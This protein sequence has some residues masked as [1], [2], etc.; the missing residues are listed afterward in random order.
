MYSDYVISTMKK[1][2]NIESIIN[3]NI[4]V[5]FKPCN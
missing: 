5:Y 4:K 1:N 3:E 2:Y